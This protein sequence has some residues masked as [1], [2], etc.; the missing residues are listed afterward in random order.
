M[1]PEAQAAIPAL[2]RAL[3]DSRSSPYQV[4]YALAL[5]KIDRRQAALAIPVL[6]NTLNAAR[7]RVHGAGRAA[8]DVRRQTAAALGEF[9]AASRAAVA[10]LANA[11]GDSDAAVRQEAAKALGGIGA[12]AV[13]IVPALRKVLTDPDEAVGSEATAAL[14][15]IGA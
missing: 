4:H 13:P 9:A 2:T 3:E 14:K 5:L 10:A 1:G 12:Q 8:L 6:T 7:P 15:K 11:L